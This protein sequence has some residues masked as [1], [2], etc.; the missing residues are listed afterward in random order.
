MIIINQIIEMNILKGLLLAAAIVLPMRIIGG[1]F[2]FWMY[3]K[4]KLIKLESPELYQKYLSSTRNPNSNFPY[5]Q[6]SWVNS[7]VLLTSV[8]RQLISLGQATVNSS[9]IFHV[10]TMRV[11][12]WLLLVL[13][14]SGLFYWITFYFHGIN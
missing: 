10:K 14:Y 8:F 2:E 9:L 6:T 13:Y 11:V 12:Y 7:T 1:V 4:G 5:N 3:R